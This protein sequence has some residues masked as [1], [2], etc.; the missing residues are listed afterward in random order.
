M[1]RRYQNRRPY[2]R[3]R[4]YRRTSQPSK[5]TT[6]RLIG[7]AT[8]LYGAYKNR[9]SIAS[10]LT[11]LKDNYPSVLAY[12]KDLGLTGQTLANSVSKYIMDKGAASG[13]KI[14]D[15]VQMGYQRAQARWAAYRVPKTVEPTAK[16]TPYWVE[17]RLPVR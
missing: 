15:A 14:K 2:Y 6:A 5:L 4:Q 3:R 17:K 7:G 10:K 11:W 16:R 8:L 1:V 13:N 9:A 12:F